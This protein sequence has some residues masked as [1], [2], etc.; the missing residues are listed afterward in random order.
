[1]KTRLLALVMLS[2]VAVFF[3]LM[4]WRDDPV[5]TQ[6][7]AAAVAQPTAQPV[8]SSIEQ[9]P[10][11]APAPTREA[12][13]APATAP[14]EAEEP[15]DPSPVQVSPWLAR[16]LVVDEDDNPAADA[17]ITIWAAKRSQLSPGM[18]EMLGKGNAYSGHEQTPLREL[19]TDAE[20]RTSTTLELECLTASASKGEV[21]SG[22]TSLWHTNATETKFVLELPVLL[23]G[24]VVRADG[25]PGAGAKVIA[26]VNG[27]G[28]LLRGRPPEPAP[29]IAGA[30]GRFVIPVIRHG[31]YSL[32]AELDGAMT[33]PEHRWMHTAH[34][35]E[36]VLGFP[37]AITLNGIV[38]D[39]EGQPVRNASVSIW[40]EFALGD[41][42]QDPDDYETAKATSGTDGRF[43]VAVRQ[44]R[45][46]QL[47][48]A[49]DGH[50]TSELQWTE[51]TAARPHAEARLELQRY[52]TIRGVVQHADGSPF[53]GVKIGAQLAGPQS[54][55][56]AVPSL[57]DRYPR[58]EGVTSGSDGGFEL[59]VHPGTAWLVVAR[60]VA[61]NPTLTHIT[62]DVAPGRND[63]VVVITA[64]DLA[65]CLVQGSVQFADGRPCVDFEIGVVRYDEQG[66]PAGTTPAK[67][68]LDGNRFELPPLS[69]GRT[70]G[71]L[72]K[73]KEAGGSRMSIGPHAPVQLG[74]FVTTSA[75][76]EVAVRIDAWGQ[77]P[78]QVL[79]ADG[80]PARK[81]RVLA[82]HD[83]HLGFY[84]S[85]MPVDAEGRVLLKSCAPGPHTLTVSSDTE[86]L[87]EQRLTIEPGQNPELVVRLPT[88]SSSAGGR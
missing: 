8:A 50:A 55:A 40:R 41:P 78:V 33:F 62:K 32:R 19:H 5:P 72:V 34:P 71:I 66:K 57:D 47:L 25:A 9:P 48:A 56:S 31:G 4:L 81:V 60:P 73:P 17:T 23:R 24:C 20:G 2:F 61:D 88:R 26:T 35:P 11:P 12:V 16:F 53:A 54:G 79:A 37:G 76:L 80:T 69:I 58:R 3:T 74:P 70:I 87:L 84:P 46:Y 42:K 28:G 39:A 86:K 45:R 51:P 59:Q 85:P 44:H 7:V 38:V 77:Q 36:V 43:T 22:E 68:K 14:T 10:A 13:P 18:R 27:G 15:F 49:A 63:V 52:A 21:R 67:P 1:M 64:E 82:I 6:G 65:G 83:A 29:V 75:G 30:D